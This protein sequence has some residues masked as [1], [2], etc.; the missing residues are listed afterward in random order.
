MLTH[1]KSALRHIT[2]AR[3]HKIEP[4]IESVSIFNAPQK[5]TTIILSDVYSRKSSSRWVTDFSSS[6]HEI[7]A[8]K[9]LHR[10]C[11]L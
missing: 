8:F 3:P 9:Q 11:N 2:V 5:G 4:D 1:T 6:F 7:M 10:K